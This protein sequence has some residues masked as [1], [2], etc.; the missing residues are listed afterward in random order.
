MDK[1]TK[2]AYEIVR[3]RI[4]ENLDRLEA[5]Q[6]QGVKVSGDVNSLKRWRRYGAAFAW[7]PEVFQDVL[8]NPTMNDKD[9]LSALRAKEN[10][11]M[12]NFGVIDKIPLHH[13]IA[14]RTGGDLGIRTPVDQWLEVRD[15]VFQATGAKPGNS[16][17]N[18][19]A[20]GQF[21]ELAHLGR[22][23]AKGSVFADTGIERRTDFP[24]LH[25]AGQNLAAKAGEDPKL[26]LGTAQEQAD[27]LI[28]SVEQQQARFAETTATP[29]VQAQRQILTEA[30]YPE[31]FLAD[32][33][34]ERIQQIKS[35]IADTPI[36]REFAMAFSFSGAQARLEPGEL[37][38]PNRM[39]RSDLY[40]TVPG[41]NE[42][43]SAVKRNPMGAA[44]GAASF[45]QPEAV[46]SA[47][48]GDYTEAVTQT[49]VGAG[50]GAAVQAAAPAVMKLVP[51]AGAMVLSGLGRV[52]G[53]PVG[54][55]YTGLELI[56][57]ATKGITGKGIFEPS[58]KPV[59]E[60]DLEFSTL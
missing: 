30:G 40:A 49:A 9:L 34:I 22:T 5:L 47:L 60:E 2:V 39:V 21:D 41:V 26:V 35:E 20:A 42:A 33:P 7:D 55:A 54:A 59:T 3:Q 43:L 15:R 56:D 28:P 51:K 31:A 11:L 50:I 18:L 37:Y 53:G 14:N 24:V 13:I 6:A 17:A 10:Q 25:R 44:V 1:E 8:E 27:V 32:T 23:G 29:E 19:N 57:A 38:L 45:I 46:T 52:L 48:Q 12:R 58:D 36:P 4:V 16:Q